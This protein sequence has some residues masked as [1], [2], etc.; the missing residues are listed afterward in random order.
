MVSECEFDKFRALCICR[1]R[2]TSARRLSRLE[3]GFWGVTVGIC[4][5]LACPHPCLCLGVSTGVSS[6]LGDSTCISAFEAGVS[7]TTSVGTTSV[8]TSS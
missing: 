3:F 7:R 1:T 6:S 5:G 8:G 4:T 2:L